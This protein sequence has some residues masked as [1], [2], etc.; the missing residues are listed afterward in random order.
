[1]KYTLY[2][3]FKK[4]T[5][6][7]VESVRKVYTVAETAQILHVNRNKIYELIA[8]GLLPALKLGSLKILESSLDTFLEKYNGYDLSDF[9]NI[10]KLVSQQV[11]D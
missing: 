6:K 2:R 5:L 11:S 9:D 7:G 3:S 8:A 1:M 4:I 10:C